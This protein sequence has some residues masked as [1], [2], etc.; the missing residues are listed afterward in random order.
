MTPGSIGLLTPL[1][2][3]L[4]DNEVTE[5]LINRPGE[6]FFEKKGLLNCL[7]LPILTTLYLQRLFTFIANENQQILNEQKPL[8]SGNLIDGSRVQLV[9]PPAVKYY[10]LAIRKSVTRQK[11]LLSYNQE[12]FFEKTLPFYL[13]HP[14][15]NEITESNLQQLFREKRW[16][17]FINHAILAKKNIVISGA[18]ASGKTTFLNACM[19]LIP[20]NERIITLEDSYE[21][22]LPH[23]NIVNLRA[24]KKISG[25]PTNLTLQDLVQCSLRLRPDRLIM[26]EI[27]GREVFDFVNAAA[28]GHPGTLTTIHATNPR[29]AFM[30][31]AQLYKLNNLANMTNEDILQEL[32]AV[33][34]VII[35]IAKIDNKRFATSCYYKNARE[36]L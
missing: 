5:I 9:I 8:L 24:L 14:A 6:V 26:G 4:A 1:N 15:I 19:A 12:N 11:S 33:I 23:S 13:S 25:E 36:N 34:D 7:E 27:R 30:R 28:S 16:L 17:E 18:T 20:L 10:T 21:I 32:H 31:M 29:I 2:F 35:Q 3:L 22:N